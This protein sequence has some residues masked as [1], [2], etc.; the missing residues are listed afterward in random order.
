MTPEQEKKWREEYRRLGFMDGDEIYLAARKASQ[1]EID[2]LKGSLEKRS[3]A[4]LNEQ[5]MRIYQTNLSA[6][7]S[8]KLKDRD[9]EIERLKKRLPHYEEDDL[10]MVA[11]ICP[12]GESS[13]ICEICLLKGQVGFLIR[14]IKE[15]DELIKEAIPLIESKI[16]TIANEEWLEKAKK[17][18][19]GDAN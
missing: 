9:Q 5:K 11:D 12:H 19:G 3:N 14:M 18:V 4:E 10:I 2:E 1:F 13:S 8:V 15:R 17:M 16:Y 7:L 6:E